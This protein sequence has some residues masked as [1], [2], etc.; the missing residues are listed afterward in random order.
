[1]TD[2]ERHKKFNLFLE[3]FGVHPETHIYTISS[4]ANISTLELLASSGVALMSLYFLNSIWWVVSFVIIYWILNF[5]KYLHPFPELPKADLKFDT[6]GIE[7]DKKHFWAWE[8]IKNESVSYDHPDRKR[9]FLD[10]LPSFFKLFPL[11]FTFFI[12]LI[13]Q[14]DVGLMT[15]HLPKK[16]Y[17]LSFE[18]PQGVQYFVL[19]EE[20]ISQHSV[21]PDYFKKYRT[22]CKIKKETFH[23]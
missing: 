8:D 19:Q 7:K 2:W 9:S 5:L 1:M 3:G 15:P 17:Y 23:L 22:Y 11:V 21:I 14:A 16:H 4:P 6:N 10:Y 12:S 20:E 18:T 13:L